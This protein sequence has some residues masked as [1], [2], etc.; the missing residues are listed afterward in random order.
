MREALFTV[1]LTLVIDAAVNIEERFHRILTVVTN[2]AVKSY[3]T[4]MKGE[5]ELKSQCSVSPHSEQLF[6]LLLFRTVPHH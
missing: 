1:I 6:L 4:E 3:F 2:A 5:K